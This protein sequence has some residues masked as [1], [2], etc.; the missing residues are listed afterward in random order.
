LCVQNCGNPQKFET[1][2]P[3]KNSHFKVCS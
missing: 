2:V 1:L 3:A